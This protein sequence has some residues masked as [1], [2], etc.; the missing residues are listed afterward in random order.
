MSLAKGARGQQVPC[1]FVVSH[2]KPFRRAGGSVECV[3]GWVYGGAWTAGGGVEVAQKCSNHTSWVT[4]R[5][6]SPADEC[7][8]DLAHV[9]WARVKVVKDHFSRWVE[10]ET[11]QASANLEDF[12]V[13]RPDTAQHAGDCSKDKADHLHF[14][15]CFGLPRLIVVVLTLGLSGCGYYFFCRNQII[16][17]E[18]I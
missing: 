10:R 4:F 6:F 18:K 8:L 7:A 13:R 3:H 11:P 16:V 2:R 9:D 5:C 12:G 17:P 14:M 1:R 15:G